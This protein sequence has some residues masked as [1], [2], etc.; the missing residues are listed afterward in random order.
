MQSALMANE[1]PDRGQPCP[2]P[3]HMQNKNSLAPPPP[4]STQA[5]ISSNRAWSRDCNPAGNAYFWI[6]K[7]TKSCA[8][9]GKAAK[10]SQRHSKEHK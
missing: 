5:A 2:M 7:I 9:D 3:L 10:K 8:R 6:T 1:K 4:T